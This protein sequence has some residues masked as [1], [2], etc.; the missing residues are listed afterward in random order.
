MPAEAEGEGERR[1]ADEAVARLGAQHVARIA[2]ADR[3]HVAMEMHGALRLAGR[4]GGE[5]D[6]AD[7][8][9]RRVDG[10]EVAARPPRISASSPSGAPEPQ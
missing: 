7:I 9:R 8:V 10:G 5:A 6:Q 4:A 3:Q 2:V 1:R